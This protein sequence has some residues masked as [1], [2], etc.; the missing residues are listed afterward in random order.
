MKRKRSGFTLIELLVVIAIIAILAAMLLPALSKAR[1]KARAA[2]CMNNLKQLGIGLTLY[3][4]DYN[5][6][7]PPCSGGHT[8][9]KVAAKHIDHRSLRCPSHWSSTISYE[10]KTYFLSYGYNHGITNPHKDYPTPRNFFP[11]WG[12]YGVPYVVVLGDSKNNTMSSSQN[13]GIY[14]FQKSIGS[15]H[16]GGGNYLLTDGH[17]EWWSY[18]KA[19]NNVYYFYPLR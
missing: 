18:E 16:S 4:D 13:A 9:W 19:Y 11:R 15:W 5:G 12:K 6:F 10:D 8:W 17:V 7:F 2:A 1:E 14:S 3:C